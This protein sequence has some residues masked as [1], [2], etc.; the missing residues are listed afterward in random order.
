MA[1]YV[2]HFSEAS[3]SSNLGV[4]TI[5]GNDS[6][7]P[8]PE[9]TTRTSNNDVPSA[10]RRKSGPQSDDRQNYT[11][12]SSA[13][14]NHLETPEE[15]DDYYF[16][17]GDE[18]DED[19]SPSPTDTEDEYASFQNDDEHDEDYIP[20]SKETIPTASG[21]KSRR[22]KASKPAEAPAK[23]SKKPAR[24]TDPFETLGRC[25]KET[26]LQAGKKIK[27][28]WPFV[29]HTEYLPLQLVSEV[30]KQQAGLKELLDWPTGVLT[31]LQT[32]SE[33]T[34]GR[35]PK[36]Q[37][38]LLDAYGKIRPNIDETPFTL[39][40]LIKVL[41]EAKQIAID[42]PRRLESGGSG[43]KQERLIQRSGGAAGNEGPADNANSLVDEH[44]RHTHNHSMCSGNPSLTNNKAAE[45]VF[46]DS[47]TH[48]PASSKVQSRGLLMDSKKASSLAPVHGQGQI[49]TSDDHKA[50]NPGSSAH[51]RDDKP[52]CTYWVMNGY[53][54]YLHTTHGCRYPHFLPD[55]RMCKA[56]LPH[57]EYPPFWI[58][59]DAELYER[60]LDGEL[61]DWTL[62][63]FE[64]RRRG[65][66]RATRVQ[67]I[68]GK[69]RL[70]PAATSDHPAP[71]IGSASQAQRLSTMATVTGQARRHAPNPIPNTPDTSHRWG[72]SPHRHERQSLGIGQ[73]PMPDET[74][75]PQVPQGRNVGQVMNGPTINANNKR[76]LQATE[77]VPTKR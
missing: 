38:Y 34:P 59:Q 60:Y 52:F 20:S 70:I 47:V 66:T 39:N 68:H 61:L 56:I 54:S 1:A 53:C 71:V 4:T 42:D 21:S 12:T 62:A 43:S 77:D 24:S 40:S 30:L 57:I 50:I 23:L 16:Q 7:I 67:H 69:Q 35:F 13:R 48:E 37:K 31:R 26:R 15:D 8:S 32:L 33:V 72:G 75:R 45:T 2:V 46:P 22:K 27:K 36:A 19:Y 55:R 11:S 51:Q 29:S 49:K 25:T 10:L 73:R 41:D 18:A 17:D 6:S 44:G 9:N 3:A 76:P 63:D 14:G 64:S 58:S 74:L 65:R 5:R 28:D